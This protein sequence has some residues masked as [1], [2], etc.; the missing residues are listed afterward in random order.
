MTREFFHR[1]DFIS[2]IINLELIKSRVCYSYGNIL[3]EYACH[4][5]VFT[6]FIL[7]PHLKN[8]VQLRTLS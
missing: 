8:L 1:M 2:E 4:A 3:I 6:S 7:V 5:R